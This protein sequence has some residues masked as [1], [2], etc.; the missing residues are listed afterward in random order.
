[1]TE[2]IG[3]INKQDEITKHNEINIIDDLDTSWLEEFDNLDKEYKN[4]YTEELSFIRFHSIYI[5]SENEIFNIKEDKV[6][7]KTQGILQKEELIGIIKRNI[8]LNEKK[9]G[10]MSVL[11]FNINFEPIQLKS[12]LK[13]KKTNIGASYLQSIGHLDAIKLDKS[14]S[15]FHDI[16][17]IFILFNEKPLVNRFTCKR[18]SN[19]NKKTK[20]NYLENRHHYSV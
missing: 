18:M 7:L 19:A 3:E 9:Y 8:C 13:S 17:D 4:Y 2:T 6:L 15:I 16:N 12:F 20:R 1:M 5:N 11:K 10:L 14:I